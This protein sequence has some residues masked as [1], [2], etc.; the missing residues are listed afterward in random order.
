MI[1]SP[2]LILYI[3]CHFP[4]EQGYG[5]ILPLD[6]YRP[7]VE[8]RDGIHQDPLRQTLSQ[9]SWFHLGAGETASSQDH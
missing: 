6:Y 3:L 2:P 7:Q 8:Q 1:Y 9:V 5:F 4:Q